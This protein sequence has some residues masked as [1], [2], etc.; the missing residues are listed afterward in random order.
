L[1]TNAEWRRRGSRLSTLETGGY[2][3]LSSPNYPGKYYTDADCRWTL[4]VQPTQTIRLTLLDFELDVRRGGQCHDFL[5][6]TYRGRQNRVQPADRGSTSSL[7][8]PARSLTSTSK[9]SGFHSHVTSSSTAATATSGTT[10]AE[11]TETDVFSECGSL[12]K[13]VIDVAS[14]SVD[15]WFKTGQSGLTQRGFIMH[16]EGEIYK[17]ANIYAR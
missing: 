2:G 8:N 10:A 9:S 12:G 15:V 17:S 13:Q 1:A 4:T 11:V 14:D 6:I 16:F 5:R 3:Y 7:P